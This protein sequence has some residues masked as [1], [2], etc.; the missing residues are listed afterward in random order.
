MSGLR[1]DTW[2]GSL[3]LKLRCLRTAKTIRMRPQQLSTAG[4]GVPCSGHQV[5]LPVKDML[6]RPPL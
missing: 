6:G 4:T 5:R 2:W 3:V 1:V